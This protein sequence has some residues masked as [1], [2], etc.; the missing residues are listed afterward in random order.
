MRETTGSIITY[1]EQ[2]SIKYFVWATNLLQKPVIAY[3]AGVTRMDKMQTLQRI[4]APVAL[5]FTITCP[6]STD[7]L[8]SQ[9][10]VLSLYN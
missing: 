10:F 6:C 8:E 4:F 3:K 5:G 9:R 7:L 1:N 2:C